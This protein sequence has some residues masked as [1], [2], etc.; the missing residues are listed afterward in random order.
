MVPA[1]ETFSR[2]RQHLLVSDF[3]LADNSRFSTFA[4]LVLVIYPGIGLCQ[5][6]AQRN[7][8]LPAKILLDQSVV[9]VPPVHSLGSSEVVVPLQL[10]ASDTF[11]DIDQ[12]V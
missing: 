6:V 5:A 12:L 2:L 4:Q 9:A 7:A 1:Y 8:R 3:G 10:D 11:Y